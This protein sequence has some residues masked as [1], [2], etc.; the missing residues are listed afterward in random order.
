M[1]SL[2]VASSSSAPL[3]P[4]PTAS[5]SGVSFATLAHLLDARLLRAL[6]QLRFERATPV[7]AR[8]LPLALAGRDVLAQAPTGSGKTLAYALPAVQ[9]ILKAK[10][11]SGGGH[12]S[13]MQGGT[14]HTRQ[15]SS[16]SMRRCLAE[17]DVCC[18]GTAPQ[19]AYR[20]LL[21][22]PRLQALPATSPSRQATRVLVLV[23]TRELAAQ[24]ADHVAKL[25]ACTEQ[26]DV[27]VLDAARVGGKGV[28]K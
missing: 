19:L 23:P 11:V 1:S 12:S 21:L 28:Q 18:C 7:Q 10:E 5:A 15:A 4:A 25:L 3:A 20:G 14:G 8:L 26:D 24:V 27:L 16:G 22:T 9:S 2:A 6:A 17:V 13:M